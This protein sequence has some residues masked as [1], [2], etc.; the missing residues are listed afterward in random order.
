MGPRPGPG[1][2]D[3]RRRRR[4]RA[5]RIGPAPRR[6]D[7]DQGLVPDRGMRHDVG[8]ARAR[9]LRADRGRLAGRSAPRGRGDPVRQDQPADLRR[10]HPELQRG[11]RHHQQSARP[12]SAR[13]AGR[14]AVRPR[15]SRWA[16]RRSS[17][18]R[19]I[20]GSIRVP[21]HYSGVV[22]PQAELRH[23]AG[24]RPD[25]RHARH[26]HPGRPR[27]RRPD[28]PIGATTSSS[29]LDVLV[30]P[31][32]WNEP[33]WRLELPPAGRLELGRAPHRRVARRRALPGRR[34]DP[35][36]LGDLV[37][38]IE[39]GRRAASTPR[40][41]PASRSRRPT[42]CSA[43]CCSPRC[44]AAFRRARSSEMADADPV[45]PFGQMHGADGR[46]GIESGS[47]TTN[48]DCKSANGGASSSRTT[49]S[50]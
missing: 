24:P 48:G 50:C 43:T 28:G 25:P 6:A 17:W 32:R 38:T 47:P 8:R 2:G 11:V 9:R 42:R 22:G 34:V 30:G 3:R 40:P 44:R 33:A 13:R 49:T 39:C 14:R 20:G 12:S 36:V 23:R 15:R 7:D 16:S 37:A 19:D 29:A 27:R 41:G 26:A 18:A 21:A 4:R 10:R 45:T 5:A 1:G 31:D 46:C 35:A